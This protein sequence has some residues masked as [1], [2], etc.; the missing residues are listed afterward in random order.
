MQVPMETREDTGSPGGG[1]RGDSDQ[2]NTGT[3]N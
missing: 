3:K 2:L 1:V